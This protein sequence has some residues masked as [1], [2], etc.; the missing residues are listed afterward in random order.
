MPLAGFIEQHRKK[1]IKEWVEFARSLRPWSEGMSDKALQDHAEELLTALVGDMESPQSKSQ[2]A[3][4]SKGHA[5]GGGALSSVGHKHASDRLETRFNEAIDESLAE[6]A[7]RYSELLNKTREQFLAI[8]GHDLR[9]PLGAI[10]MGA[11][12]LTKSESLDDRQSRIATRILNSA[13]RMTRMTSYML[14]L[15]RTRLGDSIPL[16]RARMDLAPVC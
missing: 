15:A 3:E 14:D 16:T 4:K 1:I 7:A 2:Q 6:A 9:N 13:G 11:T 12:I 5:V 8:L 10:V